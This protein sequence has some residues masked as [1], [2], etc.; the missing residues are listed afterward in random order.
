M[1]DNNKKTEFIRKVTPPPHHVG[2]APR[3]TNISDFSF[4][5]FVSAGQRSSDFP[6]ARVYIQGET[7]KDQ[8]TK[9]ICFKEEKTRINRLF[10]F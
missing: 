9:N 1:A 10:F 4:K 8:P 6:I 5:V 3:R 2:R 7:D